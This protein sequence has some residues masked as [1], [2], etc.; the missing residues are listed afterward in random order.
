MRNVWLTLGLVTMVLSSDAGAAQKPPAPPPAPP[1]D[2]AS[3]NPGRKAP[4][5]PPA[6]PT[7]DGRARR[8]TVNV[9]VDVTFTDQR[10]D[11]PS[12]SKT[13]TLTTA[14]GNWGRVRSTVNTMGYGSSPLN[15]DAKPDVQPDGRVLLA[16]NIEYG[17]K[18]VPEGKP[19]QPG[20]VIEVSLNESVTLL[21]NSGK[22]LPM[23]Q[24]ADPMSD[25]KVSVEVKATILKE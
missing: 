11:G 6:A 17:E 15:V 2:A 1:E 3:A 21:L 23:T 12:M 19:I 20:Q 4:P 14:D 22:A 13:V 24:S 8:P 16:V 18:R 7:P 25:R 9:R 5:P 10:T